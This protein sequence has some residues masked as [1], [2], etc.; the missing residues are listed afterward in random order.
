MKTN[1]IAGLGVLALLIA[2]PLSGALAADMAVKAAPLAP[3]PISWTGFYLGLDAGGAWARDVVTPT[4]PDGGVFPR[5]NTLTPTGFLGGGTVGYNFQAGNIVFGVEG[6]LG[7]MNLNVRK[8][9]LLGGTEANNLVGSNLYADATGRIGFVASN[10]YLFYAKGGYAVYEGKANTT[11]GLAGFTVV[12]SGSFHGWTVGGGLEYK[13]TANWS[14]KIEYLYYDFGTETA[15]LVSG[16][17][18]FPYANVLKVNSVK[19]GLNYT[20]Q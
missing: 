3:A 1:W 10:A 6:D 4:V 11:T 16:A 19:I 20:F 17:G 13:M 12:N 5:N 9:D 2:A 8:P 14:S 18:T 15:N 7:Y